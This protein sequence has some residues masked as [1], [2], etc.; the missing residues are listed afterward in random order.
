MYLIC[1]WNIDSDAWV[2][3]TTAALADPSQQFSGSF[4]GE[5]R[6]YCDES[7]YHVHFGSEQ[8][9]TTCCQCHEKAPE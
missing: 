2:C 4:T 7:D 3:D 1:I 6:G 9:S 8:T 5:M